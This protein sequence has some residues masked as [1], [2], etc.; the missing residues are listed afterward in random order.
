MGT[1]NLKGLALVFFMTVVLLAPGCSN[2]VAYSKCK[3]AALV[4]R[5][6][7]AVWQQC[8]RD[9][10]R[11]YD[12]NGKV[13]CCDR[14]T[15]FCIKWKKL[16]SREI[17]LCQQMTKKIDHMYVLI[18]LDGYGWWAID[19]AYSH[20]GTHDMKAVW[21]SRYVQGCDDTTAYWVKV[22]SKYVMAE[23]PHNRDIVFPYYQ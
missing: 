23:S 15:A 17:R 21:G 6:I 7:S 5:Q 13:N 22:F 16:Y 1:M 18:W 3:D 2:P 9:G 12:G 4:D 11:D 20:Y 19:P 8:E 14:A 10:I